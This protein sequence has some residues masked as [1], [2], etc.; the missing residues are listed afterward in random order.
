MVRNEV[1]NFLRTCKKKYKMPTKVFGECSWMSI[2]TFDTFVYTERNAIGIDLVMKIKEVIDFF[3]SVEHFFVD[4]KSR[5]KDNKILFL[6]LW[7]ERR[8]I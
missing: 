1:H 4:K 8:K 7:K 5:L 2:K 6:E 3:Y